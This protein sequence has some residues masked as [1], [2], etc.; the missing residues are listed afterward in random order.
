METTGKFRTCMRE[1]EKTYARHLKEME[2]QPAHASR[3]RMAKRI[4]KERPLHAYEQS[5]RAHW[6]LLAFRVYN[7]G[8]VA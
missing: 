5:V 6:P 8:P 4:Y 1:C 2:K 7:N 3:K